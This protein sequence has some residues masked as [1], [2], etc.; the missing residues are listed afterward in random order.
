[1]YSP[2]F[3]KTPVLGPPRKP[4]G[5]FLG[6]R[7]NPRNHCALSKDPNVVPGRTCAFL[8]PLSGPQLPRRN[9]PPLLGPY[10]PLRKAFAFPQGPHILPKQKQGRLLPTLFKAPGKFFTFPWKALL[11][12]HFSFYSGKGFHLSRPLKGPEAEA[13]GRPMLPAPYYR[14]SNK[15]LSRG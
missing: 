15:C 4:Q 2:L 9:F 6:Y 1:M 3:L 11:P 13:W 8:A 12:S 5:V 10:S 7:N 14:L